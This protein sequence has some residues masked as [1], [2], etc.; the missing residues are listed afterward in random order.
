MECIKCGAPST[1]RY[2]PDLDIQGIGMCSEHEKEIIQDIMISMLT[3]WKAF[4]KKYFKTK[5]K[6]L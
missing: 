4:K 2:S 3:N 6:K 5:T 1:K